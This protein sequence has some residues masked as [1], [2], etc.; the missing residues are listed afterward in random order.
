MTARKQTPPY[1]AAPW[2]PVDASSLQALAR[3]D[4]TPEQQKRALAW[5]INSAAG[6]YQTTFHPGEPDA[7]SFAEGRRF[8]GLQCVKL[9]A[10]NLNAIVKAK[11]KQ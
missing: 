11:D 3:G 2:E 5:V 9:L 7:S 6:T 4:A 8:V 10:L 1:F